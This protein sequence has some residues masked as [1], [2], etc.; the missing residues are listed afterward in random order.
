MSIFEKHV[1]GKVSA[2][3]AWISILRRLLPMIQTHERILVWVESL[4]GILSERPSH[5]KGEIEEI[6]AALTDLV[7]LADEYEDVGEG[8]LPL[9]PVMH[10][11]FSIWMERFYPTSISGVVGME[12]NERLFREAL[13]Q[14]GKRR[15]QVWLPYRF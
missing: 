12:Y 15:P 7:N 6:S 4:K 8:E 11:L 14:F 10:R 2:S 5:K 9:N 13:I 3:A 1:R